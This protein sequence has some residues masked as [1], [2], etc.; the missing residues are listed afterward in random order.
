MLDKFYLWLRDLAR[1]LNILKFYELCIKK[2]KLNDKVWHILPCSE[3]RIIIYSLKK[4]NKNKNKNL[5]PQGPGL[6]SLYMLG[7]RGWLATATNYSTNQSA[8]PT[9]RASIFIS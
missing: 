7:S 4:K 8:S 3:G 9:F 6:A 5:P 1:F 2:I